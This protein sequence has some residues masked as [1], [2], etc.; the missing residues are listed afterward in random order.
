MYYFMQDLTQGSITKHLVT[1][2]IPI[3]IGMIVQTVYYLVDL[4]FVGQLGKVALAGV[5]AAGNLAF[6]VFGMTQI[7][8]VGTVALI[9][10][11]VGEKDRKTSNIIFN[12]SI[13]IAFICGLV[14]LGAGYSFS[15]NYLETISDDAATIEQGL[16]YLYWFMPNLALQFAL[17]AMGSALRGTG[18]VKPAMIV[19]LIGLGLNIILSPILIKGW[20]TGIPM[21]VAG[22]GLASS[23]SIAIAVV[24]MWHY[25]HKLERYVGVSKPLI[26][27][28]MTY[29]KK[30]IGIGFPAGGEFLLIF[31]YTAI[32][33]WLIKGFG[34]SAQAGF[35]LGSRV[36]QAIF[37]PALALAFALPAVV[38]QNFGA[39]QKE[40]VIQ[41]FK[42]TILLISL[43][44]LLLAMMSIYFADVLLTPFSED[45]EVIAVGVLFLQIIAFNYIPS[46]IIFSC[47]GL[48]QG[49][50]NTWPAFYSMASRLILFVI[51]AVWASKQPDFQIIHVWYLSVSTI[52][53]Q[54]LISLW[55]VKKEII[56]KFRFN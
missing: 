12:Q 8:A 15:I 32:I 25:F 2:A 17:V 44:L 51:P 27:P 22:A 31:F 33:F 55:L 48:L 29:W 21:G 19:Q 41:A 39:K 18:I 4:Y 40:R 3:A 37:V 16:T 47:S 11:A 14:T 10:K 30:I 13:G 28:Q 23:I 7:L 49:L 36:M 9:S 43:L 45:A 53:I 26:R 56:K 52:V 6:V 54:M 38:G 24:I 35:G 20:F 46:G 1:M 34:P 5:N 50:G 42:S